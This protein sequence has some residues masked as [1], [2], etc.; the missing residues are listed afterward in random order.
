VSSKLIEEER[1]ARKILKK[2]ITRPTSLVV[3]RKDRQITPEGLILPSPPYS[4]IFIIQSVPNIIDSVSLPRIDKMFPSIPIFQF[5]NITRVTF[6]KS[7]DPEVK[8]VKKAISSVSIVKL[9]FQHPINVSVKIIPSNAIRLPEA[10]KTHNATP[11]FTFTQA[12]A[13]TVAKLH[14]VCEMKI[15]TELI[16]DIARQ[17]VPSQK[18]EMDVAEILRSQDVENLF[19]LLFEWHDEE[20]KARFFNAMLLPRLMCVF[21]V[22]V[23]FK[24]R[25]P[26]ELLIRKILATEYKRAYGDIEAKHDLPS[27]LAEKSKHVITFT[28]TEV[29]RYAE[30]AIK[31]QRAD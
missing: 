27:E 5:F 7:L 31:A 24:K 20:E 19:D 21:L 25:F 14:D 11:I 1:K 22:P 13:I 9:G 3:E 4:R 23:P 18:A 15:K 12:S 28:S 29:E 10:L 17:K 26:G 30:Y 8:D 6:L 16:E 2:P